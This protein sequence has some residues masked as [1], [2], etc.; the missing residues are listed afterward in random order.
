MWRKI[1]SKKSAKVAGPITRRQQV[2]AQRLLKA[3]EVAEFVAARIR[4]A[5][6][7]EVERFLKPIK[8]TMLDLI[9]RV[10]ELEIGTAG[11]ADTTSAIVGNGDDSDSSDRPEGEEAPPIPEHDEVVQGPCHDGDYDLGQGDSFGASGG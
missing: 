6:K 7:E 2:E 8:D 3:Q 5:V 10:L 9:D 1:I 4:E 11:G